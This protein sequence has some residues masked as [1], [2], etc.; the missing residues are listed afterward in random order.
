M[1]QFLKQAYDAGCELAL[2]EAGLPRALQGASGRNMLKRL[3][4]QPGSEGM[5]M[6]AALTNRMHANRAG[7]A[8]GK[9]RAA[10]TDI[11]GKRGKRV[12][13][14]LDLVYPARRPAGASYGGRVTEPSEMLRN[15]QNDFSGTPFVGGDL[16]DMLGNAA[17]DASVS[18]E[19]ARR[20][21][22]SL[23]G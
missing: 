8:S 3:R 12:R 20:Y 1:S 22:R 19:A 6:A 11:A 13:D 17:M 9:Y 2:K 4:G 16:A 18:G 14:D 21:G 5:D 15:L 7:Q 23:L 10:A